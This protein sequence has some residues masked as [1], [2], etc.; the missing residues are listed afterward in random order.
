ME[1]IAYAR[2]E[3]YEGLIAMAAPVFDLFGAVVAAI[4][5]TLPT[6]GFNAKSEKRFKKTLI[7]ASEKFSRQLGFNPESKSRKKKA[8]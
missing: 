8:S 7:G 2:E 3:G 1:K 4:V 5:V 6:I